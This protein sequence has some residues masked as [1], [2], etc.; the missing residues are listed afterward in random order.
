VLLSISLTNFKSYQEDGTLP[1]APLSLL[2]GANA[3][4]KSNAIEGI[5]FLSW[6]AKSRNVWVLVTTHNPALLDALPTQAIPDVVCCYRDEDQGDSRL[7][8]L[9]DLRD[10][11]QLVAQGPLG[12]LMTRGV[13]DKVLKDK[14]SLNE[15]KAQALKEA[16]MIQ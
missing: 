14:R 16:N 8:R 4:G 13:I 7:V 5:R 2:I 15:K 1:L 6:L 10:F 11:P 9:E 12:Q 3:S